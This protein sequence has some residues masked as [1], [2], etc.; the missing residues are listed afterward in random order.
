MRFYHL[1][2]LLSALAVFTSDAQADNI[3]FNL[4]NRAF[5]VEYSHQP[6]EANASFSGA[7]LHHTDNGDMLSGRFRIEQSLYDLNTDLIAG[8]GARLLYIDANSID[9]AAL[10]LSASLRYNL[11]ANDKFSFATTVDYAP[12]VVSFIDLEKFISAEA[13]ASYQL[14]DHANAFIGTR[15][16]R[17][18]FTGTDAVTFD[19][20]VFFGISVDL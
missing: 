7:L 17:T 11:P 2:V 20:G 1:T 5:S 16:I 13:T 12:G 4:K 10:G 19:S 15:Y 6:M 14:I 18:T 9:G 3:N 8:I